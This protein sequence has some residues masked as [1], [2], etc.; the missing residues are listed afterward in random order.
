MF[1]ISH[2]M[3]P[4]FTVCVFVLLYGG[5]VAQLTKHR[6]NVRTAGYISIEV[7]KCVECYLHEQPTSHFRVPL[8]TLIYTLRL[9]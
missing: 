9:F 2:K 4:H 6:L 7:S 5:S 8:I 1:G 3:L